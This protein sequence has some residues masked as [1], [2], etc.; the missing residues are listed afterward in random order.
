MTKAVPP[1]IC[2][3]RKSAVASAE[4]PDAT[5]RARRGRERAQPR[6]E[7]ARRED[8]VVRQHEERC[9][10][11]APLL[12]QLGRPGERA[13]SRGRARRPCRS[14]SIRCRRGSA[15]RPDYRR[16][17]ACAWR[18][19]RSGAARLV[20]TRGTPRSLPD[21][22][23][24]AL[25]SSPGRTRVSATSPPSSWRARGAQRHHD[26]P[27]SE[28][29]APA[30]GRAIGDRLEDAA[31]DGRPDD[32]AARH[33]QPRLGARRR[34]DRARYAISSTDVLLNAGIVH[35]PRHARDDGRRPR[36]RAT[37]PTSSGTS[38][39]RRAADR[40]R[41]AARGRMVWLGSLSTSIIAYDPVDP[42]LEKGYTAWR[43]Y[44]QSKVATTALGFEAD[45][46]LRAREHPGRRA[47]SPIPA[48][49]TERTHPRHP[50][51]Q[52]AEPARRASPTTCRG[53]DH[54][55]QGARRLAARAR[56]RRSRGRRRR[57][58]GPRSRTLRRAGARQRRRRS[59]A[60]EESRAARAGTC[61]E[62][63]TS[64]RWPLD[65][66]RGP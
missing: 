22:T 36:D 42:Q 39:R 53:R 20:A 17:S 55:V 34:G 9:T 14:A 16:R 47:S 8:R 19:G 64:V 31:A 4:R 40:A 6:A 66:P 12:Q 24:R 1:G 3:C 26:G 61:C 2:G 7:I 59:R 38:P 51:R 49:S 5:P 25:S 41:G 60:T 45:R 32:A 10:L 58:L 57:V 18:C 27:Q 56:P 52:R 11:V 23:G 46:R 50:R 35:P 15:W 37:P 33:E 28:P 44:V 21:L 30:R 54:A 29:A 48:Y 43:A 62:E 13:C 63:A 65:R